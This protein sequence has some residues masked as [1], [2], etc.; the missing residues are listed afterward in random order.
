M[1]DANQDVLYPMVRLCPQRDPEHQQLLQPQELRGIKSKCGAWSGIKGSWWHSL[2]Q[3]QCHCNS[4]VLLATS[5]P[6]V[7]CSMTVWEE[8]LG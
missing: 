8:G 7:A 2:L 1:P 5:T 4:M 3:Q 6:T